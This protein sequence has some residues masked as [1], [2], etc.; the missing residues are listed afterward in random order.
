MN[1]LNQTGSEVTWTVNGVPEEGTY[2]LFAGYSVPGKDQSM[3]L[4]V[5]GKVFGS[6]MSLENYAHAAE[7]DYVKGWTTTYAW[8]TLTKG[9]NTISLSCQAGDQCD[10]LLSQVWLKQGQVKK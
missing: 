3:T 4:K 9:T 6:K 2:T 5:N 10:V 8:P 7:G 1:G